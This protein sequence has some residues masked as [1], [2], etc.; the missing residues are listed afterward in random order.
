MKT[1]GP[2]TCGTPA[3]RQ[4][5]SQQGTCLQGADTLPTGQGPLSHWPGVTFTGAHVCMSHVHWPLTHR[6]LSG[7]SRN[8]QAT[9]IWEEN[10]CC[11][12]FHLGMPVPWALRAELCKSRKG[13]GCKKDKMTKD[14][15]KCR[16]PTSRLPAEVGSNPQMARADLRMM[17]SHLWFL[18]LVLAF[19]LLWNS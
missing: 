18:H 3:M 12:G 8:T 1:P 9:R 7:G 17:C 14:C 10:L 13:I 16:G 15:Y 6:N 2:L 4:G 19:L 11:P 5:G